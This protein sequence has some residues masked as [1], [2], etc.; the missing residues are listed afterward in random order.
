MTFDSLVNR[1]DYFS[2][3]YLAEVL[4]KDLKSGLLA[5][6]KQREEDAAGAERPEGALPVTPRADLR[7]LRRTY[8]A[9]RSYFTMD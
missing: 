8:F 6:W 1:G 4:P 2:A 9:S 5:E 7:A 3:H